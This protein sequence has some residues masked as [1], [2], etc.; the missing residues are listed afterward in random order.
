MAGEN[1]EGPDIE[2]LL[3]SGAR[4]YEVNV[5]NAVLDK[6]ICGITSRFEGSNEIIYKICACFDPKR[7]DEVMQLQPHNLT[8]LS[9]LVGTDLIELLKE[10]QHFATH[11]NDLKHKLSDVFDS[12]NSE[13]DRNIYAK[14]D[15]FSQLHDY[16]SDNDC[17]SGSDVAGSKNAFPTASKLCF[18]C[19]P[20]AFRLGLPDNFLRNP[21]DTPNFWRR[22][23]YIL[24]FYYISKI[25]HVIIVE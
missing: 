23:P 14:H 15:Y 8:V 4:L 18:N 25:M 2:N 17:D 9:E 22:N 7:F 21:Y 5:F 1:P 12:D 20:C 3:S 6:L 24:Y 13:T 19:I 11:Y 10:L 16:V